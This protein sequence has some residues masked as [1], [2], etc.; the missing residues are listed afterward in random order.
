MPRS[1]L[2]F[3]LLLFADAA[4]GIASTL[5]C[6][7]IAP[8]NNAQGVVLVLTPLRVAAAGEIRRPVASTAAIFAVDVPDGQWMVNVESES[9]WHERQYLTI[10][11]D[12]QLDVRLRPAGV[13]LG[14][15]KTK[16]SRPPEEAI[17]R[18]DGTSTEKE[19]LEGEQTC[20]IHDGAFRCP[21]PAGT[22]Q[23]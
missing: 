23:L 4:S 6:H 10:G 16:A 9:F 3:S 8:G 11:G 21:F 1:T 19:P 7:L 17:I 12:R 14:T 22:Y 15:L 13:V 2:L 18:F 5:T 20:P